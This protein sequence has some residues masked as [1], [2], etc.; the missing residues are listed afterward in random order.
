MQIAVLGIDLGKNSCS[1]SGST[2]PAKWSCAGGCG[3]TLS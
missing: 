1:V 3:G 2:G